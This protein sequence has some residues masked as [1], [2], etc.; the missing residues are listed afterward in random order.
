MHQAIAGRWVIATSFAAADQDG[1]V[2]WL[3]L[4]EPVLVP[5]QWA[6]PYLP[7]RNPGDKLEPVF[8]IE[9][10]YEVTGPEEACNGAPWA[11]VAGPMIDDRGEVSMRC[12]RL[13]L[14]RLDHWQ[15]IRPLAS[16]LAED[17]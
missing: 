12:D 13:D 14:V 16:I 3:D 5:L 1:T 4:D 9:L 6:D 15:H 10:G 2:D 7:C 8:P 11:Y 17:R